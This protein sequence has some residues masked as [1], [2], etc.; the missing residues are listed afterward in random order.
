MND[1][2]FMERGGKVRVADGDQVST[3]VADLNAAL[4]LAHETGALVY[5]PFIREEL[6]RLQGNDLELREASRLFCAMGAVGHA[7]RLEA[8]LAQSLQ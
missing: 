7:R 6:G 1:S 5:E 4:S 2:E 8:Y 3:V